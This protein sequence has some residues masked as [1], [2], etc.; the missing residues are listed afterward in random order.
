VL[1]MGHRQADAVSALAA[2]GGMTTELRRDLAGRP[3]ALILRCG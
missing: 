3:R 2:R 1:E